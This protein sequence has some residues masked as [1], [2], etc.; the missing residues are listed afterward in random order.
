MRFSEEV[1]Q[2]NTALYQQIL[3]LPF[4]QELAQGSLSRDAFCTMSFRMPII[5]WPMVVHLQC[6]QPRHLMPTM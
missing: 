6:V 4:N 3:H 5:Y 2:R 1:W